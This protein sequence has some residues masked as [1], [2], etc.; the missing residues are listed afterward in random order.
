MSRNSRIAVSGDLVGSRL[1]AQRRSLARTI[2]ST[3]RHLGTVYKE[4]F[5]AR[6]ELTRGI[7]EFSAVFKDPSPLFD[8]MVKLNE[9]LWPA[10]FRLGIGIGS[11]DVG[12][13]SGRAGRMD[14]PAFHFAAEALE[15]ARHKDAVLVIRPPR[16]NSAD[17][18]AIEVLALAHAAIVSRWTPSAA[19]VIGAIRAAGT[20]E[21]AARDLRIT[22]Q[23]ASK[24]A[25]RG[26]F[27]VLREL[28][29]AG[30]ALVRACLG[31]VR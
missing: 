4:Q 3:L 19:R 17:I 26:D 8:F 13:R 12:E 1:E 11:I 6:P 21:A 14:G 31:G 2:E 5:L 16:P 18:R 29:D 20:Q 27:R 28:E 30:T 9:S 10:R 23:A 7:D 24:A 15:E 25:L 22:Q